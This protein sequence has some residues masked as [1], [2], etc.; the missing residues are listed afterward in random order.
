MPF[1]RRK[2][3]LN[4]IKRALLLVGLRGYAVQAAKR[5]REGPLIFKAAEKC[6]VN[7]RLLLADEASPRRRAEDSP[8]GYPLKKRPR[9]RC[10]AR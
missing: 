10:P 9:G 6:D 5:F 2:G 8:S 1:L 3:E 7:E 4:R